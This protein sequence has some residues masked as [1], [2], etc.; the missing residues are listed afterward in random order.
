MEENSRLVKHT[1]WTRPPS[2]SL[3]SI[4]QTTNGIEKFGDSMANWGVV[5]TIHTNVENPKLHT[6]LLMTANQQDLDAN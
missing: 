3:G 2:V 1:P 6:T 4:K 5:M